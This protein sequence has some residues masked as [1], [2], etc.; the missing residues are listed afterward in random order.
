MR[1]KMNCDNCGSDQ[2]T[3]EFRDWFG[4]DPCPPREAY[5]LWLSCLNCGNSWPDNSD[6][7]IVWGL[8]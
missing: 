1:L 3:F 2:I 5:G 7:D 4:D 6:N 8:A